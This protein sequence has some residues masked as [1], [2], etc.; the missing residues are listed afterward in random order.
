M[1][2][3]AKSEPLTDAEID[4]LDDLLAHCSDTA[5]NVEELH[6][7]FSALIAGPE[8]VMPNE[9]YA[10]VFGGEMLRACEFRNLDEAKEIFHL[11]TRHWN[12]VAG[13]LSNNEVYVPL[14]REGD[15]DMFYGNHWAEG[16]MRGVGLRPEGWNKLVDDE[17]HTGCVIPM[18][19]LYHEH[20][21]DLQI[22]Q[23]PFSAEQRTKVITYMALGLL[24]AYR[25]FRR[26]P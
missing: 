21:E 12:T 15:D 11:L 19:M 24:E 1:R 23:Q 26:A 8:I 6:G 25:Y 20:D 22:C 7:F 10:E 9:Y 14:L 17:D 13:T 4:R 18:L 2:V 3:V 16:F 5:M